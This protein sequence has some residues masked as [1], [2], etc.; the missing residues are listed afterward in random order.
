MPEYVLYACICVCV[1]LLRVLFVCVREYHCLERAAMR[2]K[3]ACVP[4]AVYMLMPQWTS[5][6]IRNMPEKPSTKSHKAASGLSNF[7]RAYSAAAF[8]LK[9]GA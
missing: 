6:R 2:G 8:A 4:C 5:L 1:R 3:C 9:E 7:G